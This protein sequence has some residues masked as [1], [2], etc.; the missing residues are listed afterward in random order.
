MERMTGL[1][2]ATSTLARSRSTIELHPPRGTSR[3]CTGV[4]P[5]CRRALHS[6]ATVPRSERGTRTPNRR[7]NGPLLYHLSYLGMVIPAGLEP[8]ISGVRGRRVLRLHQGT[9]WH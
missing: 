4:D 7:L 3:I 6:S 8:A 9:E 2:P 1:E 5:L